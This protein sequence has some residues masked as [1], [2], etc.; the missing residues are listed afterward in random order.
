MTTVSAALSLAADAAL[1]ASLGAMAFFSF[2][3]APRSFAVLGS[4]VAGEYVNDVFPRYYRVNL[5]LAAV[6]TGALGL[7]GVEG[8]PGLVAVV[9][10]TVAVLCHGVARLWLVPKMEGAGEDAFERYHGWS[11]GLNALAM[12]AVAAALVGTHL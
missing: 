12:L 2:V 3:A 6:A 11:V 4:E 10:A 7:A 1:G 9:G 5:G 8:V